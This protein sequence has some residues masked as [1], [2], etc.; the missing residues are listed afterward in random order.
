[1]KV[2]TPV[3]VPGFNFVPPVSAEYQSIVVPAN[4]VTDNIDV[5]VPHIGFTLAVIVPGAAGI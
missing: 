2:F 3:T 1:V 5:P 4:A